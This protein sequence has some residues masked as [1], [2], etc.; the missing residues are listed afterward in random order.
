M[1]GDLLLVRLLLLM[2]STTAVYGQCN[3]ALGLESGIVEDSQ[4][5][6]S[7]SPYVHRPP[8]T[9][10]LRGQYGWVPRSTKDYLKID[11]LDYR[12]ITGLSVQGALRRAI[13]ALSLFYS[14]DGLVWE[15]YKDNHGNEYIDVSSESW[16]DVVRTDLDSPVKARYVA[17]SSRSAYS[18]V[19]LEV[20]GCNTSVDQGDP[21][22]IN[23][24]IRGNTI[25]TTS[26]SPYVLN[27]Q[28]TVRPSTHL[29][30]QPGVMVI[31]NA[32][33]AG[34][35]IR[36]SL[37][38]AG[39]LGLP[40]SFWSS[41]VP[42][43]A[44]T[45][46]QGLRTEQTGVFSCDFCTIRH[47]KVGVMGPPDSMSLNNTKVYLNSNGIILTNGGSGT[48]S[49][50]RL[51]ISQ[52]L[53]SGLIVSSDWVSRSGL[54][55]EGCTF[56]QNGKNALLLSSPCDVEL[57]RC[58]VRS[59]GDSGIASGDEGFRLTVIESNITGNS[60]FGLKLSHSGYVNIESSRVDDNR[61]GLTRSN[62]GITLLQNSKFRFN[63]NEGIN[64]DQR[65][66]GI[67]NI[68][69]CIF[70]RN[71]HGLH[72]DAWLNRVNSLV[73]ITDCEFTK[74]TYA[75]V[76]VKSDT[77]RHTFNISLTYNKF[78]GDVTNSKAY[79]IYVSLEDLLRS[80]FASVNII[81]NNMTCFGDS[82]DIIAYEGN[83]YSNYAKI[84]INVSENSFEDS[85]GSYA[86][87]LY[88]DGAAIAHNVFRNSS[89][90]GSLKLTG[91]NS[92]IYRNVFETPNSTYDLITFAL[93]DD[94]TVVDA[95]RNYWGITD[96]RGIRSRIYDVYYNISRAEIQ[97]DPYFT[98]K[99]MEMTSSGT[100]IFTDDDPSDVG[101]VLQGDVLL[102]PDQ[103]LV[104]KRTIVVPEGNTLTIMP[105]VTL[106][107]HGAQGVIVKG[108]LKI[109]GSSTGLVILQNGTKSRWG[110]VMLTS[111]NLEITHGVLKAARTIAGDRNTNCSM[112][113]AFSLSH[114][115]VEIDTLTLRSHRFNVTISKSQLVT[116]KNDITLSTCPGAS[117][118]NEYGN[119]LLEDSE[120][121]SRSVKIFTTKNEAAPHAFRATGSVFHTG[122]IL[123]ESAQTLTTVMFLNNTFNVEE[124]RVFMIKGQYLDVEVVNNSFYAPSGTANIDLSGDA[125][126][127]VFIRENNFN[128][129]NMELKS[130]Q[131]LNEK[132]NIT[133]NVFRFCLLI[134]KTPDVIIRHNVFETNLV[135]FIK[136]ASK[137]FRN[138]IINASKN[139]WGKDKF[140]EIKVKI[141]DK[142][143]DVALPEIS[144]MPFFKDREMLELMETTPFLDSNGT[145]GGAV[146]GTFTLTRAQS[147]YTVLSNI[148]VG[149]EDTLIIDA[150]V[151]LLFED[152]VGMRVEG[153]LYVRGSRDM[154]VRFHPAN[155]GIPWEGVKV[156][157]Q[158]RIV[159][160]AG[161]TD[162][163]EGR[164]EVLVGS[165]YSTICDDD[166]DIRDANVVCRM[167][168]FDP[169][170]GVKY[171]DRSKFGGGSGE[172]KYTK[173]HCVGNESHVDECINKRTG[174]YHSEDI[175]VRCLG[176]YLKAPTPDTQ[177][178]YLEI[179]DTLEGLVLVGNITKISNVKSFFSKASGFTLSEYG[180][181]LPILEGIESSFNG[182]HGITVRGINKHTRLTVVG[183]VL[184]GN[185]K[186][187]LYLSAYGLVTLNN[188][189]VAGN[190]IGMGSEFSLYL[191]IALTNSVVK[192]NKRYAIY[193][194]SGR[195]G[196]QGEVRLSVLRSSLIE[197][198]TRYKKYKWETRFHFRSVIYIGGFSITS[199]SLLFE[200]N[201]FNG[202]MADVFEFDYSL[203]KARMSLF[204]ANNTYI[205]NTGQILRI[206][207]NSREGNNVN[208]TTN[209]FN[210]NKAFKSSAP[211]I[212]I[213]DIEA[214]S[215][216]DISG[217]MFMNNSASSIIH[218]PKDDS[219]FSNIKIHNNSMVHNQ[220]TNVLL[221]EIYETEIQNNSFFNPNALCELKV[222]PFKKDREHDARWNFWGFTELS[223]IKD[224]ICGFDVNMELGFVSYIPYL[225]SNT[226]MS[227]ARVR[228]T[229]FFEM[230]A[231]GGVVEE[232]II[233]DGQSEP[234]IIER[235]IRIRRG[236]KL[237]IHAGVKLL[238]MK[239]RGIYA[240]GSV[241]TLSSSPERIVL[242][243]HTDDPWHGIVFAHTSG[244][245]LRNVN[246]TG[247]LNGLVT[248]TDNMTL[249]D[250]SIA[251]TGRSGMTI[252]SGVTMVNLG[253][254]A[255]IKS[256]SYGIT[257]HSNALLLR[258]GFVHNNALSG[259]YHN[260]ETG[261]IFLEE[262]D[263][264]N[265]G[266]YGVYV[267]MDSFSGNHH[268]R[269]SNSFLRDHN[270][271]PAIRLISSRYYKGY[272]NITVGDCIFDNNYG[273]AQ[274][275]AVGK[276]A[277][278][279]RKKVI[280]SSNTFR[281]HSTVAIVTTGFSEV[282]VTDNKANNATSYSKCLF[283]IDLKKGSWSSQTLA[284]SVRSNLISHVSGLCAFSLSAFK[285]SSGSFLFNQISQSTFTEGTLI[286]HL[287]NY[288]L[289]ENIFDNP[290]SD[291][292]LKVTK[293]G[294]GYINATYNWWGT[295]DEVLVQDK[296]VERSADPRLL[297]VIHLP[298][299]VNQA[300]DC[301]QVSN[302]SGKGE[303]VRPNGC[304]CFS[305]WK[306]ADCTEFDCSDLSECNGGRCVG[307]NLCECAD[308]WTGNA[309]AVATCYLT[310]NCSGRGF[311]G[312]PD[313]CTCLS[314][315][316]GK[317]C[318]SCA[319]NTWGRN[320][321]PCPKCLH[322]SC[323]TQ[324]GTCICESSN[325]TGNLCAQCSET[326][327]GPDCLPLP[328]VL[329]VS[330]D[331]GPDV[332]GTPVHIRGHNFK[333]SNTSN[334]KCKFGA[335]TVAAT[336]IS[337]QH[338]TCTSPKLSQRTVHV[339]ISSDGVHFTSNKVSYTFVVQCPT[340]ACGSTDSPPHGQC[341]FGQCTCTL[342]WTGDSCSVEAEPPVVSAINDSQ[343]TE[344]QTY[345]QMMSLVQGSHTI[346]WK[347]ISSPLGMTIDQDT[348]NI[349]WISANGRSTPYVIK[350][351]AQNIVGHDDV[352]WLLS[353][354]LSYSAVV[355]SLTPS[356]TL[357]YP[358]QILI[359]GHLDV[360]GS[361]WNLTSA[362]IKVQIRNKELTR[363]LET[364]AEDTSPFLFDVIYYPQPDDSGEFSVSARHPADTEF[365]EQKKW[366]VQS[367]ICDPK[368]VSLTAYLDTPT[369][370]FP[371]VANLT[372]NGFG[373]LDN[374][375]ATIQSYSY[376]VD[377]A[378]VY[379][380]EQRT[381]NITVLPSL[382]SVPFDII[383]EQKLPL[384]TELYVVVRSVRGTRTV[385]R[386]Q[387]NLKIRRPLL[388]LSP[389]NIKIAAARGK[390]TIININ[391]TNTGEATARD[392]NVQIPSGL[393]LKV[394]AISK[395]RSSSSERMDLEPGETA[396]VVLV[397]TVPMDRQLGETDGTLL[398]I[399]NDSSSTLTFTFY[400]TSDD[401]HDIQV[402]VED[403]YTYFAADKPLLAEAV[404]TLKQPRRMFSKTFI[405]NE[406]GIS[407]FDGIHADRYTLQVEAANHTSKS[408]I[409]VVDGSTSTYRV[410]LQRTAVTYTWSV[411][412]TTFE[413]K[414]TIT[415]ESTFETRVPMPVVTVEPASV[416]FIPYEEGRLTRMVFTLTNHGFIRADNVRFSL[417]NHPTLR[418]VQVVDPLGNLDANTSIIVP[419]DVLPKKISK[420]SSPT[421]CGFIVLYDYTC[422]SVR[423]N[424]ASVRLTRQY[425]G[426]P[427]ASCGG[428]GRRIR[429]QVSG[430]GGYRLRGY[431]GT[432]VPCDCIKGL[433]D[434]CYKPL[435]R[436][437][438]ELIPGVG[439]LL[440]LYDI[441]KIDKSSSAVSVA[442]TVASYALDCG[443]GLSCPVC[444]FL[445]KY[446]NCLDGLS[447]T[448]KSSG[449]RRRE[450]NSELVLEVERSRN[451]LK[452][453]V[454]V[455]VEIFGNLS[456]V[457][458][459]GEWK[460]AF[461]KGVSEN[462]P[463]Q[464][465]LDSSEVDIILLLVVEDNRTILNT[466]LQRWN[467][468]FSSW[469]DGIS[470]PP[471]SNVM[472]LKDVRTLGDTFIENTRTVKERGFSSVFQYFGYT[473][474][475]YK[476]SVQE[477]K[478]EEGICAKVRI[479]IT[480]DLVLTR[481]AF[482]ARLEIENGEE[483]SLEKID[484][485]IFITRTGGNGSLKNNLFSIGQP[486]LEGISNVSG[487]GTLA[488]GVKGSADWLIVAYTG[489]AVDEDVN[490]DVGGTLSYFVADKEF[491]VPLLPDTIT[492][493]PNPSL[494][495]AY[496][497]EKYV[498]GDDPMTTQVE[499]VVPF[500]LAVMVTNKGNGIARQVKISSGQPEI[501]ENEKGLL[502]SFKITRA[503]LGME[504]I[505]PSLTVDFGDIVSR[506]TKTARWWMT[507]TLKGRFYNY[508]AT[509]ENIN[510]L[511]DSQLSVFESI[512]Y[513]DM[514]HQVRIDSIGADGLD[515]FLVNDVVDK[516]N[517]PDRLYDSSNGFYSYP[518][519]SVSAIGFSKT[520]E[521][522]RGRKKYMYVE[523]LV[524]KVNES[525]VYARV[526]NNITRDLSSES[527]LKVTKDDGKNI[528][529]PQN[530]WLTSYYENTFYFHLFANNN[531]QSNVSVYNA[532]FGPKNIYPPVFQNIPH[533]L[534]ISPREPNSDI[535]T[536]KAT[537]LD[538]NN[539]SYSIEN[540]KTFSVDGQ[541]GVVRNIVPLIDGDSF[542]ITILA[543]DNGIPINSASKNIT[544]TVSTLVS[545]E[546]TP[547]I[548][549]T[550]DITSK[551]G[552]TT[553]SA[554]V[555]NDTRGLTSAS[556]TH[557]SREETS[558][559][560]T[561][562]PFTT[563]TNI[564]S[565]PDSPVAGR[566]V[567]PAAMSLLLGA[568]LLAS[569]SV[570][571]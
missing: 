326:F 265:N 437:P 211:V 224:R 404:V 26:G 503:Q 279:D 457:D 220:V 525:W 43:A 67:L 507:S 303:C 341:L 556:P 12:K 178:E 24:D 553:P 246:I 156:T 240:S 508:S 259:I 15:T 250:C 119:I 123:C 529:I 87:Y 510:P 195:S 441:S 68:S 430:G 191:D 239:K 291:Y 185:G 162:E 339:E 203:I 397:Y 154:P 46:W 359:S 158:L 235:S 196:D 40:I 153:N 177:L 314:Q 557:I 140:S 216:I 332:G 21:T 37:T 384:Q 418:F 198:D 480:Q 50:H 262:M 347:L 248:Y 305:G 167:A 537:D 131:T 401:R 439:C 76:Y 272:S 247:S 230:G 59:N 64:I 218:M 25:W 569:F 485:D 400:I 460:Q 566:G 285:I 141:Y 252:G 491:N 348:G 320:C 419:I 79:A 361:T 287:E 47:A 451:Y 368:V 14:L 467:N 242:R 545:T 389:S 340:T 105:N 504:S 294:S 253:R 277:R 213:T 132:M 416:N 513:H 171:Y 352:Q 16:F 147:P 367:M 139:Y 317:S 316:R 435:L 102:H 310:N 539:V 23:S 9:A 446:L 222:A 19:R 164:V 382:S 535:L 117:T 81:G 465:L 469:I 534:E 420:R 313:K 527:L 551:T 424:S 328:T 396:T 433:I 461:F 28:V 412:K 268:I 450:V 517:L 197:H 108:S 530:S 192:Y 425:P 269:L 133:M 10:R 226:T 516:D 378:W 91:S 99:S 379:F 97:I 92:R 181:S 199:G 276:A 506:E 267:N 159:R 63:S 136:F 49:F 464:Y 145:L 273:S 58:N 176:N 73:R 236:G 399:S 212:G 559:L 225:L 22:V 358:T 501:I 331:A 478:P 544:I 500:P 51:Q 564:A 567:I 71:K 30:I 541:S 514:I 532:V 443:F 490:Y 299:S 78:Q 152:S 88:A 183:C 112:Y 426:Q 98:S 563:G 555:S 45:L 172:I 515:D 549:M 484:V 370:T 533:T 522:F 143:N 62:A 390:Q 189:T 227:E 166:F 373:S 160:F 406:T 353:I 374:I 543:F 77:Y 86:L 536:A 168:G 244:I 462:S 89:R 65:L 407:N 560:S 421:V 157:G 431:V 84:P 295:T 380:G 130:Q 83:T 456:V 75:G 150:G 34:I 135:Y 312:E 296:I 161:G 355:D 476:K 327:Y 307:P 423:T 106:S 56:Q 334:Y 194:S 20:Y 427:P 128:V 301:S 206:K 300:F 94:Q 210:N 174:C 304:S 509:F 283:E 74:N 278:D 255:I 442:T 209:K 93:Y 214:S 238:F 104:V 72:V 324:T 292:E 548:T 330:P 415:L 54:F 1:M 528:L 41:D 376:S 118:K 8:S 448:C 308:G 345:K 134:L 155:A 18:G 447:R 243:N 165:A 383:I 53:N 499:P 27:V 231:V 207:F 343:L 369:A 392:V 512:S 286:L 483:G 309:C 251:H 346:R 256:K 96:K 32:T 48:K 217:N 122:G 180:T 552:P 409:I 393:L 127:R 394:A 282:L 61:V 385:L 149:R 351:R 126:N 520:K 372:N 493:T 395:R 568:S 481:D 31:F 266:E 473:M 208:I 124:G 398:I 182:L 387:L 173:L 364:H 249:S 163:R 518:V 338:L 477:A 526:I 6:A 85:F 523:I 70:E 200:E 264:S 432:N 363:D 120:F 344:G 184:S 110:G 322:G 381:S 115:S 219:T 138:T 492:V 482:Q 428:R 111:S 311:C 417:P 366:R 429:G 170:G 558:S 306:G 454:D 95:S 289:S 562:K 129:G 4:I 459:K 336:R 449:R 494:T 297:N 52:S 90:V 570:P 318:E 488:N 337:R 146:D 498:Q 452:N 475:E 471:Q 190:L 33:D 489:A 547:S 261:S 298:I 5:T 414:Y 57:V 204:I 354:P 386:V 82:S 540:G 3:E 538:M 101:G 444:P 125:L 36:G 408:V 321:A 107:F 42:T 440:D 410:F 463:S 193:L 319:P 474:T 179:N 335:A 550:K 497:H 519:D 315:Y 365:L 565:T 69:S 116:S 434:N 502:V 17:I 487:T 495:L 405:T 466:F 241:E 403:E 29:Q 486:K 561:S 280:M 221:I 436:L 260:G 293:L 144:I 263:I 55:F 232:E 377:S 362:V 281:G 215:V 505:Q 151:Q 542:N 148:I 237:A 11:F 325:W 202:N 531:H 254:T 524:P 39:I 258:N 175:S 169:E 357:A 2:L 188:C 245:I 445:F 472:S 80:R 375:S 201:V 228:P 342:P 205:N 66:N 288:T 422:G 187:G 234:Y 60:Q 470:G 103:S 142:S 333:F 371:A 114:S 458:I 350:V 402:I 233:L 329:S 271:K 479:R 554:R 360:S 284:L 302:C 356:G 290:S 13:K 257:I 388:K 35:L 270:N 229:D 438:F 521:E 496:F 455:S 121:T 137:D 391:V 109:N 274:I 411:T 38:A 275:S 546:S 223:Q 100:T 113:L 453:F 323:D 7:S 511:G 413:D 186:Y 571:I 468:T 44:Q 349:T